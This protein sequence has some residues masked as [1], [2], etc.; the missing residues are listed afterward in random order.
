MLTTYIDDVHKAHNPFVEPIEVIAYLLYTKELLKL[1][2]HGVVI[3]GIVKC[4]MPD[5]GSFM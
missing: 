5:L 4:K 2:H 3:G 1:L